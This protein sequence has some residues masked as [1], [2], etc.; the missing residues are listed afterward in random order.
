MDEIIK[1]IRSALK[2][3]SIPFTTVC[4]VNGA[5]FDIVM[6]NGHQYSL[7]LNQDTALDVLI[8]DLPSIVKHQAS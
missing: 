6:D 8:E 2:Q 3:A 7:S 5:R 4:T 1:V